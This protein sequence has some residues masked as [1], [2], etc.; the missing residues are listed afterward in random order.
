MP[1]DFYKTRLRKVNPVHMEVLR[2]VTLGV[3]PKKIAKLLDVGTT[4]VNGV[5]NSP[6]GKEKLAEFGEVRD[7]SVFD[8]YDALLQD[9]ET[10]FKFLQ[11]VRDDE[12]QDISTRVKI[13][14][15]LLK[16]FVEKTTNVKH[17]YGDSQGFVERAKERA[18]ERSI[19]KDAVDADFVE[20][21]DATKS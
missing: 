13:A 9:S 2:L 18:K 4:M 19:T 15:N 12:K 17:S 11:E 16:P 21:D 1:P 5:I 20:V 14:Q 8:I 10:N 7:S 6:L 3:R